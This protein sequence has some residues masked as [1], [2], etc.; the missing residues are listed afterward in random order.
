M[1]V[2]IPTD[3]NLATYI[4]S[5]ELQLIVF[6]FRFQFNE[7]DQSWFFDVLTAEGDPIRQGVKVVTN[8]PLLSRIAR[9]DR[10]PGDIF[11]IDLTGED[12]RPGLGELGSEQQVQFIYFEPS[13]IPVDL[14][15]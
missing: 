1:P 6:G 7:R 12:L 13:E 15:G 14:F 3:T 5:V 10:P 11:A 8:F 9:L 2:I 4:F